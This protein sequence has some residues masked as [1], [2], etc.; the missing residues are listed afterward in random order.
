VEKSKAIKIHKNPTRCPYCHA[1]CSA[2]DDNA[3]CNACL[4]RHHRECWYKHGACVT[5]ASTHAIG[6]IDSPSIKPDQE[7]H[8]ERS[9]VEPLDLAAVKPELQARIRSEL[10]DGEKLLWLGQPLVRAA[11]L[12]TIPVV[13]FGII[14][15]GFGAGGVV[16][17]AEHI[18]MLFGALPF[19]IMGLSF[20]SSPYRALRKARA[21]FYILTDQRVILYEGQSFFEG[22]WGGGVSVRSYGPDKLRSMF[23]IE[24]TNGSG[25]L[26]LED[27]SFRDDNNNYN[28]IRHG[29]LEI[30]NV[31]SVEKLIRRTLLANR[32]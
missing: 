29:L 14:S 16:A 12:K 13:L 19:L 10:R 25:S 20:L 31:S 21:T 6:A 7:P 28:R 9:R 4:T 23:R 1:N 11:A 22:Q 18:M 17:A 30:E 2:S 8:K 15:T 24:K 27:H 26:I 3:V 5:C 32:K